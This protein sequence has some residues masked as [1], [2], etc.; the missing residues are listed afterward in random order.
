M[1]FREGQPTLIG[2][3]GI[4]IVTKAAKTRLFGGPYIRF[5]NMFEVISYL[6]MA[7]A[8]LGRARRSKLSILAK[9]LSV[10]GTEKETVDW[11]REQAKKRLKQFRTEVGKEPDTFNEFIL[12]R[13]LESAIGLS[14]NDWFKAY[15]DGNRRIMKA[16][17]EKVPL[18]KAEPIIKMFQLEGIGFGSSF[19]ELTEKLYRNTFEKVDRDSWVEARKYGLA[20][21]EEPTIIS[22]EEQEEIVLQMVAGYASEYYPELLDQLDLR[23][24]IEEEIKKSKGEA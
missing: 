5:Y 8:I 1:P 18:E 2:F 11:L 12:F 14:M 20:I 15:A 24:F 19:P 6:Y 3:M 23:K 7:G 10:P 17:D 16:A 21:S 22:L 13:E 9:M 4:P